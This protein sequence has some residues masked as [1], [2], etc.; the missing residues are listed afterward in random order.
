MRAS[1]Y[2]YPPSGATP[3]PS[4]C[5]LTQSQDRDIYV[6]T[7]F[8]AKGTHVR[9]Q[10]GGVSLDSGISGFENGQ[11]ASRAARRWVP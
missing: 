4:R 11:S 2:T 6:G 9:L 7:L 1:P 8:R 3:P 10:A 5:T